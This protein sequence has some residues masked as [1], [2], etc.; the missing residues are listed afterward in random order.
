MKTLFSYILFLSFIVLF[1]SCNDTKDNI[2]TNKVS[3]SDLI[4]TYTLN[5]LV[6][7]NHD[8]VS[9]VCLDYTYTT[10]SLCDYVDWMSFVTYNYSNSTF[11]AIYSLTWSGDAS[12]SHCGHYLI[13]GKMDKPICINGQSSGSIT[14]I[15]DLNLLP[16]SDY[17]W[18]M[19]TDIITGGDDGDGKK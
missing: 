8:D 5:I 3:E 13:S 16:N 11:Q 9:S 14:R 1:S 19:G 10:N 17:S 7:Q 12:T 15:E 2:L 18:K 4:T 6:V